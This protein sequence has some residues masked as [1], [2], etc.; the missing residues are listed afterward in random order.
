MGTDLPVVW[1]V[2]GAAALAAITAGVRARATDGRYRVMW[3]LLALGCGLRAAGQVLDIR[4][5]L[6]LGLA[7]PLPSPADI[8]FLGFVLLA[9]AVLLAYPLV[10][11]GLPGIERVLDAATTTFA[12]VLAVWVLLIDQAR[13][14]ASEGLRL[15]VLIAY[16]LADVLILV[17]VIVVSSGRGPRPESSSCWRSDSSR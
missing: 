16:P 4:D 2:A 13:A 14:V 11:A 6:G 17:L 7:S 10:D 12:F 5:E 8:A 1:G 9:G 3:T 15:A